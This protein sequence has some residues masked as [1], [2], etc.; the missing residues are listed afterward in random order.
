VVYE[1][2]LFVSVHIS[3]LKNLELIIIIIIII[4]L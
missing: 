3:T 1:L 2:K 4:T